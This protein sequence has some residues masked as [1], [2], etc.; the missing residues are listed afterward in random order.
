MATRARFWSWPCPEAVPRATRRK[1]RHRP[2]GAYAQSPQKRDRPGNA[3]RSPARDRFAIE[4]LRALSY[5]PAGTRSSWPGLI[6]EERSE[7]HSRS[8]ATPTR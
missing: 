7:F 8:C 1:P 5:A 3:T 4:R 6:L 2:R